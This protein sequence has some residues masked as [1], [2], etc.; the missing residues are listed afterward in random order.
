MAS[1][2]TTVTKDGSLKF[3]LPK[4]ERRAWQGAEVSVYK[5]DSGD[6]FLV[7]RITPSKV[8]FSEMLRLLRKE[9]K[10][11]GI[12]PKDVEK[13]IREMRAENRKK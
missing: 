10:K 12:T 2:I 11:A 1:E 5:Y 3:K 7:K 8:P 13:A 6:T 4:S 9:V